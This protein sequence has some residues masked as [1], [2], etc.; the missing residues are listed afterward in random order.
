MSS[1]FVNPW[2][3]ACQVPLFMG[4]S[5]QEYWS[6]FPFPPSGDLI[7]PGIKPVSPLS[8]R[9]FTTKPPGKPQTMYSWPKF[10][11]PN[12]WTCC[13]LTKEKFLCFC[14]CWEGFSGNKH[15]K[16]QSFLFDSIQPCLQFSS[17][18]FTLVT[19]SCPTLCDPMDCSRPDIPVHLQ[20]P[21]FAQTHVHR[22]GDAIQ[23]SHLLSSPSP[24]ALNLSQHQGLFEWVSSSHQVAK[25]LEFQLQHQSFQWTPRTDL[26]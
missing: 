7:Y 4:F 15:F 5:R 14:L 6:G 9:F 25:V 19:Q 24:P 18:Q 23:P 1:S 8:G 22:V 2:T 16:E 17:V 13:F 11:F 26:L 20:L 10:P 12:P 21:G 3:V